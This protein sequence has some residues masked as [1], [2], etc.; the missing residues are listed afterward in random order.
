[1]YR[2]II[3]P[4]ILL[5]LA[6]NAA[7][8]G[9]VPDAPVE[10][11]AAQ[12]VDK[13]VAARGGLQAWR[14]VQTITMSGKLEAGGTQN[15]ELPFALEM[16][17]PRKTR[18]ELQFNGQTAVQVYDGVNGWKLRPFLNRRQVEPYTP[19]ELK[20][21]SLQADLDGPLMD[22]NAKGTKVE[23]QG[24]QTVEG[25]QAYNLKLTLKSGQ[26]LHV[27]VDAE[28]FLDVKVDGTP[29]RLDGKYHPV[30]TY[31]R[32]FRQV[33][34]L[35]VPYV[36]ETAVEG[37]KRTEKIRIESVVVNPKLEDSHFTKPH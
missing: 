10:L 25:R 6:M 36:L 26:G 33:K 29:R 12:I 22:Y 3:V 9:N 13:N 14:A 1:M 21:A 5:L 28:T 20:A 34:G 4:N 23:V 11:T 7:I 32:D 2:K 24:I 16:K 27:W 19:E 18:L 31:F 37:A 35:M 30:E 15:T 8:A 17:R